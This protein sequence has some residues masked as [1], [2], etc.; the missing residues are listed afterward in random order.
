MDIYANFYDLFLNV[1]TENF[2]PSIENV[3]QRQDALKLCDQF[4][5]VINQYAKNTYSP[6]T[7]MQAIS[8]G[9]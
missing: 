8:D 9:T 7:N 5:T 6:P 3:Y 1:H 2:L 4:F